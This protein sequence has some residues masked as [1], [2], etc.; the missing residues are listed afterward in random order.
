MAQ[1]A[2][3]SKLWAEELQPSAGKGKVC[4]QL[5]HPALWYL[6]LMGTIHFAKHQALKRRRLL[7]EVDQK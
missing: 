1:R 2:R 6:L 4:D 7:L 3:G 5:C